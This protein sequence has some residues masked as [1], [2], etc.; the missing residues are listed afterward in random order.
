MEMNL[1]DW[2]IVLGILVIL[3]ILIDGLRR[4]WVSRKRANELNFGLEKNQHFSRE[5]V[6]LPNGGARI[7]RE[8]GQ[9]RSRVVSSADRVGDKP[10]EAHVADHHEDVVAD[11]YDAEHVMMGTVSAARVISSGGPVVKPQKPFADG[12]IPIR[13]R[14][15]IDETP[16]VK[17][18]DDDFDGRD[19]FET[20]VL[21][22]DVEDIRT[23]LTAVDDPQPERPVAE[24][25]SVVD[26]PVAEQTSS[27]AQDSHSAQTPKEE[28]LVINVIAPKG[29]PYSGEQLQAFFAKEKL[30]FGEMKIFHRHTEDDG[31][32]PILFSAVN[33]VEPGI[34]DPA[35]MAEMTTPALSFFMGLPCEDNAH[36]AFRTMVE[37]VYNLNREM[38][39]TL[40]DDQHSGLTGQTLEHYRERI[41]NFERRH[42]SARR[43]ASER[44]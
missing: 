3:G 15:I 7:S 44:A 21:K 8:F 22:M 29:K 11:S 20:P 36:Q 10:A 38:G 33:A 30:H 19:E 39:G 32:G 6:E 31:R 4:I 34:F 17:V 25:E 18:F 16:S 23:D 28:F 37:V 14:R 42:L 13:T 12:D 41:C 26:E 1:R 35:T 2:L 40:K 43:K 24:P 5:E 27:S 9:P